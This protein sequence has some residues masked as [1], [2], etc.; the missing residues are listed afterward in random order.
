MDVVSL[1][2]CTCTQDEASYIKFVSSTINIVN[3]SVTNG[4]IPKD[5]V[6]LEVYSSNI[7]VVNLKVLYNGGMIFVLLL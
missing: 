1:K 5:T 3:C 4:T 6:F 7:N 2:T